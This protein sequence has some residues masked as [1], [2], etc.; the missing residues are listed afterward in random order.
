M[1]TVGTTRSG[2]V[3]QAQTKS[4]GAY[5][6]LLGKRRN[7]L[8]NTS[9]H[10]LSLANGIATRHHG[11]WRLITTFLGLGRQ[12]HQSITTPE[13][14][15]KE[16]LVTKEKIEKH[17]YNPPLDTEMHQPHSDGKVNGKTI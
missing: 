4:K 3:Y 13:D 16:A 15:H 14:L 10:R 6:M 1:L 8:P 7:K 5:G 12:L 17:Y 11:E 9:G 2:K